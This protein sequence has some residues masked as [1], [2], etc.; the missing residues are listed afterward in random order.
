ML[1]KLC[2]LDKPHF[3]RAHIFPLGFFRPIPTKG[4]AT[5]ISSSGRRGRRLQ[6]AIYDPAMLCDACEHGIMQPLDDYAIK[7]IR[8]RHKAV[9]IQPV[10]NNP[11]ALWI[12][13]PDTDKRLLRAFI[14]SVLWRCSVSS[15]VEVKC[16]SVGKTY[17]ERIRQDL[18]GH[19]QFTYIDMVLSCFTDPVH[20]AFSLPSRM[21][22]GVLGK[23]GDTQSANGWLLQFPW[24]SVT[25]SL[26]Q[27]PHPHRM[28]CSLDSTIKGGLGNV[29]VSTSLNTEASNYRLL[30]I[31]TDRQEDHMTHIHEAFRRLKTVEAKKTRRALS[32]AP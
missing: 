18:L 3:A 1:C 29:M 2:R 31:E 12:F 30:M 32:N 21:R 5:T 22:L 8:D 13:A 10:A 24:I 16:L 9:R 28:S 26:D 17:E 4:Q 19:G 27:R 25:V 15:Q 11:T 23:R 6:S 14:A 7:I 20:C